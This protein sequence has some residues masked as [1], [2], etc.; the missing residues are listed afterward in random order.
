ME[1]FFELK[2]QGELV[3]ADRVSFKET[4]LRVHQMLSKGVQT[5]SE[6]IM[7]YLI[8]S[9][10]LANLCE[11]DGDYRTAIQIMRSALSRVVETRENNLKKNADYSSNPVAAMHVHSHTHKIIEIQREKQQR[12][13]IW[14]SLILRRER[15]RKRAELGQQPLDEDEADE[16]AAE[17]EM[18]EKEKHAFQDYIIEQQQKEGDAEEGEAKKHQW[19]EK[20]YGFGHGDEADGNSSNKSQ[21]MKLDDLINDLHIEVLACLYRCE[22]KLGQDFR[23]VNLKTTKMLKIKGIKAPNEAT[24]GLGTSLKKRYSMKNAKSI[25]K[26]IT[27]F[28]GLQQTL[29]EA[30]K[31]RKF[32]I[33]DIFSC[34]SSTSHKF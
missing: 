15:E 20:T 13:K 32:I 3:D 10:Y 25:A 12:Y 27:D 1:Q 18:I 21:R 33:I 2:L 11:E 17:I 29:Q 26:A 6:I 7:I 23:D 16:E 9:I 8:S 24:A 28:S 22:I 4:L 14:E 19:T 30:G 5:K 31:I 34:C